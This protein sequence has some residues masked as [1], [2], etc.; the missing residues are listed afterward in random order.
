M[1]KRTALIGAMAALG[2]AGMLLAPAAMAT[3][4]T[5]TTAPPTTTTTPHESIW[6]HVTP[7][8]VR[9]GATVYLDT[10]CLKVNTIGTAELDLFSESTRTADTQRFKATVKDVKPGRYKVTMECTDV[11]PSRTVS[12]TFTVLPKAQV[13]TKPVG[14]PQTGGGFT[15]TDLVG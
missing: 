2:V 14:A 5:T 11:K 7:S 1:E 4:T 8:S 13:P 12:A 10:N 6:L 9:P 3:T 15:A